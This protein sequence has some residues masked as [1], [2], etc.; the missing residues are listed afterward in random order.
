MKS[1]KTIGFLLK[2]S[3]VIL[4]LFFLYQ[5]L[6]SKGDIPNININNI[7]LI[8]IEKYVIILFVILMMF[9]NWLLEALKWR[10]LIS[11]IEKVSIKKIY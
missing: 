9:I 8:L 6:F 5:Q 10:A 1:K 3:I 4:A 2:V 7:K 11:K